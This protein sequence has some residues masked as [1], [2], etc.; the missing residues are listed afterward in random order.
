MAFTK[1]QKQKILDQYD[2]WLKDSRAVV[3]LEYKKMDMKTIDGLR[4]KAREV[5]GE[6]HIAKNT[7]LG[8]ALQTAG[9]EGIIQPTGTTLCA[10]AFDDAPSMAKV[11]QDALKESKEELFKV[12]MGYLDGQAINANQVKALADLPP[13][14]VM[15]ATLLGTIMAPASKLVRT[16]AEPGRQIAAV[17]KARSEKDAVPA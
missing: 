8:K 14:P 13:L 5:G 4:A 12:K 7:L 11:L 2:A 9:Y 6:L 1:K 17:I 16:L 3:L 15:R 10:F